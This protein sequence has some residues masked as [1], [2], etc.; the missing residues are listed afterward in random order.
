MS[1]SVDKTIISFIINSEDL[2][3]R[4]T[5]LVSFKLFGFD[6][7]SYWRLFLGFHAY[8]CFPVSPVLSLNAAKV[9]LFGISCTQGNKGSLPFFFH[10]CMKPL[11][12]NHFSPHTHTL[13][14]RT[15]IINKIWHM[16]L[17]N[18]GIWGQRE[19]VFKVQSPNS[20]MLQLNPW[21]C[22]CLSNSRGSQRK[23]SQ[24]TSLTHG[25]TATTVMISARCCWLW[26]I[27]PFM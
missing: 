12:Y 1:P 18:L 26:A 8:S 16:I 24:V 6:S 7:G 19:L 5:V 9:A 2:H 17:C 21:L 27:F 20:H 10:S 4:L 25:S 14:L 13:C 23:P 3:L 11:T 22:I 15:K